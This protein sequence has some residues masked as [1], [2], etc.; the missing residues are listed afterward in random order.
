MRRGPHVL[1]VC[2]FASL[3]T[4]CEFMPGTEAYGVAQS[5]RVVAELLIDPSSAQ[6]QNVV[7]R[8]GFVC[9]EINGKNRMGAFVGFT[10]FFVKLEAKEAEIDPEFKFRD[11]LDAEESCRSARGNSYSSLSTT[12]AA[13]ERETKQR[14]TL[15]MQTTFDGAWSEHCGLSKTRQVYR[16]PV[17]ESSPE[18]PALEPEAIEIVETNNTS[19]NEVWTVP[20]SEDEA[21]P[22]V[23]NEVEQIVDEDGNPLE[24]AVLNEA[25]QS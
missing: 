1:I 20:E 16:P 3:S 21:L 17:D 6:F 4:A 25:E 9:G 18:Q 23:T 22:T 24:E 19:A 7:S 2:A 13:C 8:T 14:A 12:I 5:K 10:R 11:L 15:I